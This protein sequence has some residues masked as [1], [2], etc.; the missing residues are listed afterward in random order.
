MRTDVRSVSHRWE[1]VRMPAGLKRLGLSAVAGLLLLGTS[2]VSVA[3]A[4]YFGRNKVQ[5]GTFKFEVLK[6]EHFDIMYYES[7]KA[8]AEVAARMAER[9]Y[10]RLSRMLDHQLS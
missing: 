2:Q 4:Q 10:A 5:Y 3:H 7:E 9:W 6:T 8:A 1:A